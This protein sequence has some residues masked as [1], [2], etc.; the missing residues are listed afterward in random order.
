M[1][2]NASISCKDTKQSDDLYKLKKVP[3]IWISG[4]TFWFDNE[5]EKLLTEEML[6]IKIKRPY[7]H[8][9]I[10]FFETY[11]TNHLNE[12]RNLKLLFAHHHLYSA[13]DH[14]TFVSPVEDVIF[15]LADNIVYLVNGRHK[16]Q[17]FK[18]CSVQP[19]WNF[20]TEDIWRNYRRGT[21]RYQP[22][23]KGATVSLFAMNVSMLPRE[24][25]KGSAWVIFGKSKET[26]A[27]L[28]KAV[29]KSY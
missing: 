2:I 29:L 9:N 8:S 25:T 24:T 26:L 12:A 14:F 20:K 19:F 23:A 15:H 11:I 13:K 18:Q 6:S 3:G 17:S 10:H 1:K 28:N 4:K 27:K 21:L 7:L 5:A 16:R 22:M